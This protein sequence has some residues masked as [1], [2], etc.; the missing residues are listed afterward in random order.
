MAKRLYGWLVGWN[1]AA[2]PNT[3]LWCNSYTNNRHY[4][5]T[6]VPSTLRVPVYWEEADRDGTTRVVT[7][8]NANLTTADGD[9]V[10]SPVTLPREIAIAIQNLSGG[11]YA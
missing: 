3:G 5:W 4:L 8:T 11:T 6:G 1:S 10:S 2:D 7:L 9:F